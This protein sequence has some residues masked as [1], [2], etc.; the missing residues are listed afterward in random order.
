[1]WS[2]GLVLVEISTLRDAW[3]DHRLERARTADEVVAN[4]ADPDAANFDLGLPNDV[5]GMSEC[6]MGLFV[7][8]PRFVTHVC[9][10][11]PF[12]A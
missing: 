1:M 8:V 2:L 5:P 9:D 7:V 10:I 3:F 6:C 4:V 11:N 12:S